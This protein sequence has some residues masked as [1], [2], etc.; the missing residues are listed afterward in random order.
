[1]PYLL[2]IV[3]REEG[4]VLAK[5]KIDAHLKGRTGEL[6][7]AKNEGKKIVGYLPNQYMPEELVI[8]CGAIPLGLA[9]G[10]DYPAVLRA[11]GVL[12]R[13]YDTFCRAQVGYKL[14]KEP[15]YEM[16]DLYVAPLVDCNHA[17]IVDILNYHTDWDIFR[18]GIPHEKSETARNFYL[19]RLHRLRD[20]LE[21]VTGNKITDEGLRQA[22]ELCNRERALLKEINLIRKKEEIPIS[23]MDFVKLNHATYVADK[24]IMV[25]ALEAYYE[26]LNKAEGKIKKPR[27][28]LTGSSLPVGD[29]KIYELVTEANAEIVIEQYSEA[30]RDF[31]V[32]VE[33]NGDL[34][35]CLA[36]RYFMKKTC[37]G[38]FRPVKELLELM[39]K[40]AKDFNV[41]GVIWYQP[42]YNDSFDMDSYIFSQLL[43]KEMNIPFLKLETDYDTLEKGALRTRVETFVET[44]R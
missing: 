36:D 14:M 20:K 40:L 29:Y 7:R 10:G 43:K 37:H 1:M 38:A 13:W 5:E 24:T 27:L 42:M 39:I 4:S 41:D 34:M 25:E 32:N 28:M 8:A 22:I 16:A 17:S 3:T 26:E 2:Q 11:G 18:I 12:S 21:T 35:G 30:M 33:L 23:G 44:I 6:M 31:L 19:G 15:H 9:R